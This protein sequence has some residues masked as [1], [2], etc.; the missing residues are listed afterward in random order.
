VSEIAQYIANDNPIAAD[1]WVDAIFK[2]VERLEIFPES[3]RYVPEICKKDIRE[4]IY[5]HYRI[6]Y[7][8]SSDE[9]SILTVRH[10]KQI[11]PKEDIE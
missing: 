10:G 4:V 8:V 1:K 5:G 7:K 6:I 11:L 2:A 3:G 9:V